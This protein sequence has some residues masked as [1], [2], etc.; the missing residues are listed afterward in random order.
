MAALQ[1]GRD[2]RIGRYLRRNDKV[3]TPPCLITVD[4]EARRLPRGDG[5]D[6]EL[7]LWC[8]RIDDRRRQHHAPYEQTAARGHTGLEL[9]AAVD[10]WMR[11]RQVAWLYAHNLGYDLTTGGLVEHLAGLGW[12]VDSCSSVPEYL[13]L[14]MS[15]GRHKI[16]LTDLH[17]L[18]PMRLADVGALL[19][20]DKWR[21]PAQDAPD[22]D[23][24]AYC[25]HDVDILAAAVLA[26]MAHWDDYG[27][28]NWSLSGA[29]CGFR[30]L[31]HTLPGKSVV[32]IEDQAASVNERA[33]IY[34][35]RRYC[36]RHGDLPP[37]RYSE[38]DFTAAHATV[39][40]AHPMPVKRGP[41]FDSLD[42]H[43]MAVDGRFAVVI[44]ECEV[45][46]DVPRFPCRAGG[47]V[48]YPVGRFRTVLASP[49]IAW[50]RETG[51]LV[52][53]GRGQFHYTAS[54]YRPFFKRVLDMAARGGDACPPVVA[55][56]WK[57]W[58]RSVVGKF[59][60]RG[61][62]TQDTGLLTDRPWFYERAI[63]A[64]TGEAYWMIHYGGSIKRARQAGDGAS[65][66]PAVLALV[67]SYERVALGTAAELLGPQVTVQCDTDGLWA[68]M[69]QLERGSAA[70]LGFDLADVPRE[71]RVELAIDVVNQR[72]D[73]LQLREKH[74]VQRMVVLGPQNYTAGPY[75]R[76]SGRP[77]GLKEVQPGIWAGDTFPSV[78]HQQATSRPGVYRTEA[79]TWTPPASAVPGWVLASGAVRPVEVRDLPGVGQTLLSWE[80][81]RQR[82][83][84]ELLG[85]AQNKAL[86]GLWE[87]GA[88]YVRS[89]DDG[90]TIWD[91]SPADARAE[92][93]ALRGPAEMAE[94]SPGLL[95]MPANPERPGQ[96]V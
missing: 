55:A 5:E 93:A 66:Y 63:D 13:F 61:Y 74:T 83:P 46:T 22:A 17:H 75:T 37:G 62:S 31:R 28:G 77:A 16:T 38:L 26:L 2:G 8:A 1:P 96:V 80:L 34:G 69:G 35:G 36:W 68:D 14:T 91:R 41:W 82:W 81:T 47:R 88:D 85:P 70:A 43:H 60:Q 48:W 40:A 78:A 64:R 27:L 4:T 23:W 24:F 57:Q 76:Q 20:I 71:A 79:I 50:A 21:M 54:V 11:G 58:G 59:A 18:L 19:A 73:G 32:L 3:W 29:A 10:R 65:A 9:A 95:S 89:S 94:P 84:G 44:A 15:R 52:A 56:M 92:R 49:E 53:I 87:P 90:T 12:Q 72:L 30:A 7:R 67:E 25:A 6:Q 45:D 51:C 33:A 42:P 86:A 39:M